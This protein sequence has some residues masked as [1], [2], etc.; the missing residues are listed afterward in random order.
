MSFSHIFIIQ[1]QANDQGYPWV[2]GKN[3]VQVGQ[4]IV[5]TTREDAVAD[6]K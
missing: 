3:E 6:E 2:L 1:W 4:K 5:I